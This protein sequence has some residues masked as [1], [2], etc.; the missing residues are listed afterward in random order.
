MAKNEYHYVI[1]L[2]FRRDGEIGNL[3]NTV[4]GTVAARRGE[5]RQVLYQRILKQTCEG[6]GT[7]EGVTLF[8]DLTPNDL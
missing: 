3:A 4:S 8:F 2:Q 7:S 6:L 1:T 5:T